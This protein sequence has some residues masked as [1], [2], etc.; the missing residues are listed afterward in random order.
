[1]S[2]VLS[3][4]LTRNILV[5][6]KQGM[7][8]MGLLILVILN[9]NVPPDI[10]SPGKNGYNLCFFLLLFIVAIQFS[11]YFNILVTSSRL[12]GC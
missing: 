3:P 2:W 1:M 8:T 6:I 12:I 10:S 5:E 9:R 7:L 11:L 4:S